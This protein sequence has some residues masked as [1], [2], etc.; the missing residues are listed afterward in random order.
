MLMY[1]IQITPK[2]DGYVYSDPN[3]LEHL[4]PA[5]TLQHHLQPKHYA[6]LKRCVQLQDRD[7]KKKLKRQKQR[8]DTN[9]VECFA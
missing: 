3:V 2:Q 7:K 4:L 9:D 8:G 5:K 6:R 1:S